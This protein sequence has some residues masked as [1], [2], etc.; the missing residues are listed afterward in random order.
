MTAT[1]IR[2]TVEAMNY[3]ACGMRVGDWFEIGPEGL[4]VPAGQAFCWFAIASIVAMIPGRLDDDEWLGSRPLLACPD[5]PEALH[6]RVERV[7][8]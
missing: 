3:S 5:P 7:S 8:E 4:S 6:I 2:C 1:R